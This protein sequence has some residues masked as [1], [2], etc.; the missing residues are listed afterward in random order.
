MDLS[1]LL[2]KNGAAAFGVDVKGETVKSYEAFLAGKEELSEF[3]FTFAT[4][5]PF[6]PLYWRRGLVAYNRA[7][8]NVHPTAFDV[9]AG[10][11]NWKLTN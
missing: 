5:Q 10:L 1:P 2:T 7:L 4:E 3:L 8:T 6:I 9:Y 11:E